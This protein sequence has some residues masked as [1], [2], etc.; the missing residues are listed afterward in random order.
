VDVA[1]TVVFAVLAGAGT[2]LSPCVLPV[3]PVALAAGA[4]GGR[5]RP[6]GV[7]VGLAATFAAAA[8]LL[9]RA[10][11]AL[12]LPGDLA[13]GVAIAVLAAFGVSLLVPPLGAAVEARLSR[14]VRTPPAAARGDGFRSGLVL[15]ASLGLVYAPCAGPILAA[16]VALGGAVSAERVLIGFAYG[17]GAAAALFVVM[18]GG[19]RVVRALS[20]RAGRLQQGLG[21]LMVGVALLLAAGVDRDFQT[22]IADDLP[23]AL[24]NPT[25]ELERARA[26]DRALAGVRGG[27]RPDLPAGHLPDAGAAPEFTGTGRWL[28][29]PGG[30]PLTL[31]ALRGRVV[32]IDFW[33]YTCINCLRTLPNLRAWDARYRAAGLTVVG[34][35]TPEF[36][37]ERSTANVADAVRGNDLRYPVVQDNAYGTWYAWRN[38]YWPAKY[39][40][41]ARGHVRYW[42]FGEGGEAETEAAIRSL[43][44]EAGRPPGAALAA[45]RA[46]E[47][48][49]PGVTT[50]ET[51]LGWLRARNFANPGPLRLG[52][53]RF[54][55]RR[56]ALAPDEFV[57][58][59]A[60]E[61]ERERAVAGRRAAVE[62]DVG[63][64]R[65]F[66]VLSSPAR[67]RR[68]RVLVDGR[69]APDALAGPDVRDGVAVIRRQRLYRLLDFGRVERHRIAI[70]LDPGLAGYAFTFG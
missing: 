17:V 3:L 7:A 64:R 16:V 28:N 29:T 19:R 48:A 69:P 68:A 26:V 8:V 2:A 55:T 6:L 46:V 50:P 37:F 31:R 56:V 15:G 66:L 39:L 38:Q 13:R 57:F 67:P 40:V 24:V 49:A 41:D 18:V 63:A 14:F 70:E 12:G 9:T 1:V 27:G 21:A 25:G 23:A 65:V 22:A 51:Y 35:H 54:G 43:L 61:L 4:T 47:R 44:A 33:T 62:A 32:L 42:H 11:D 45:E 5:R 59:G 30:R 20:P 52:A 60:W 53:R 58:R 34:V 10:L 36:A